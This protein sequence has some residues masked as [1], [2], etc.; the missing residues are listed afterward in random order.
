ME[1]EE[2]IHNIAHGDQRS[3][4][5]F[6]ELFHE[7]VY[8]VCLSHL[9][10]T[11]DA[12][13]VT[14]DVFIDVFNNAATFKGN[15]AVSTWVYRIAVNK[16]VDKIRYNNRQKRFSFVTSI[17][18]KDTGEVIHHPPEFNHPGVVFEQKEN[19]AKLFA[20]IAQL[21]ENQKAAFVLK[22]IE[23]L[24]QREVAEVLEV[25]EKAV[26]SLLQ[27]AKTGLRKILGELYRESKD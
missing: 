26:E 4:K 23:G 14:Q 3:F 1:A 7:R 8:N 15:A 24:S 9:Q 10:N 6:Y 22:Q 16:S 11:S 5:Q 21:P 20:A 17:F 2:L 19:A 25:S 18:S 12:E 13:E 27:R